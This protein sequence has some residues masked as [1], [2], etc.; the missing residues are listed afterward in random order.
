[1]QKRNRIIGAI[2]GSVLALSGGGAATAFG[3]SNE[4]SID[5]Q[6]EV[7]TVRTFDTNVDSILEKQGIQIAKAEKVTPALN[8]DIN[9]NNKIIIEKLATLNITFDEGYENFTI[10]TEAENVQ[11]A[12]EQAGYNITNQRISPSLD[13]EI[14]KGDTIHI[15][16]ENPKT[17][18]F[19]GMNGT[20]TVE[21]IF[22]KTVGEVADKNLSDYN[23]KTDTLKP[24]RETLLENG[25]EIEIVRN[26]TEERTETEKIPFEKKTVESDELYKGEEEVTTKGVDGVLTKTIKD[27]K[28]NG[29][30]KKSEV[31]K[32]EVTKKAVTEV[33]TKGIKEKP[34]P[35]VKEEPVEEKVTEEEAT[36]NASASTKEEQS[37][38]S[39]KDSSTKSTKSSS[40]KT[41]KASSSTQSDEN[42]SSGNGSG[43]LANVPQW[44][45]DRFD[46]LAQCESGGNWSIN[47]GNGYFGGIQFNLSSWKAAG[48]TQYAPR[49]DLATREA[50]I[51]TGAVLQ[52][53]Q[54][55]GAWPSCSSK[56][57]Y[58]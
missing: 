5:N 54:G 55:W 53:L 28:V 16:I 34:A 17:V 24:E 57:G 45:I 13:T 23:P 22:D 7:T 52:S 9:P 43:L 47:T 27:N 38:S 41:A 31:V 35:V 3:L 42:K 4:V 14:K 8:E 2:A 1:M 26:R 21:G 49:P 33:T 11:E 25:M 40:E 18:T 20:N 48:G 50:Q 37:E 29:K 10:H 44:K 56:Y 30:V 51:K 12:L 19:K 58:I 15:T 32:E 39:P 46:Q 36:G 6:G